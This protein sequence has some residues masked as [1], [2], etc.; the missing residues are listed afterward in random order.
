MI[1]GILAIDGQ[2]NVLFT[3]PN[4]GGAEISSYTE[5]QLRKGSRGQ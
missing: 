4:N 5:H 2:A 1:T 3:A